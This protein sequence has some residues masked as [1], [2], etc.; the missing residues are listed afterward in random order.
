MGI[1]FGPVPHPVQKSL[2][3]Q[4]LAVGAKRRTT[5]PHG[6]GARTERWHSRTPKY[7]QRDERLRAFARTLSTEIDDHDAALWRVFVL[8]PPSP[9]VLLASIVFL[10]LAPVL[11]SVVVRRDV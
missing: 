11:D 2:F 10:A 8:I 3:P 6:T 7:R 4:A 5:H 9:V 1:I